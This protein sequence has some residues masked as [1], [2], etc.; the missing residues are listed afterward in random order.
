M[1]SRFTLEGLVLS[2]LI[3]GSSS[4]AASSSP[5]GSC[6]ARL[7]GGWL[8]RSLFVLGRL[9]LTVVLGRLILGR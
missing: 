5:A 1:L 6:A 7:V 2:L 4:W 8:I 9:V 3:R